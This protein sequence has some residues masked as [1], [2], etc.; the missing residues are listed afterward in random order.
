LDLEHIVAFNL[1]LV[2]ALISPGPAFVMS[3]QTTL[4]SG[5]KSGVHF[6]VGLGLMA[7][8]W[9]SLAL[10]GLE[11]VFLVFP[12]A[13]GLIKTIGAIYLLYIAA[14][15]WRNSAQKLTVDSNQNTAKSFVRGV[16]VNALN[17]KSVLFAAAVLI[18][19]FPPNMLFNENAFVVLNHF[20]VEVV[21]YSTLACIMSRQTVREK[22]IS[23]KLYLDR[24]SSVA[25]GGFGLSLLS[26]RYTSS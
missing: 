4:S 2:L 12:W 14:T 1:A 8:V 21:F 26:E 13:Y 10:V 23:L 15:I 9:T 18:V 16:L 19:V 25:L 20:L 5:R 6:G 24:I 7:A 3:I 17:P 11:A 22:Y